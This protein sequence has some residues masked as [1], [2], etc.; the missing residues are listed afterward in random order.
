MYPTTPDKQGDCNLLITDN[1]DKLH[2]PEE[3]LR[4][5]RELSR[6]VKVQASQIVYL[7]E[8]AEGLERKKTEQ[9]CRAVETTDEL[10][11][12]KTQIEQQRLRTAR[13][14]AKSRK[15][16][17]TPPTPEVSQVLADLRVDL[18][19]G[20]DQ[21]HRSK[22]TLGEVT[23]KLLRVAQKQPATS[24]YSETKLKK[25][26][27]RIRSAEQRILKHERVTSSLKAQDV[28]GLKEL[29]KEELSLGEVVVLRPSTASTKDAWQHAPSGIRKELTSM[30]R[31]QR[32]IEEQIKEIERLLALEN[33]PVV[34]A[35]ASQQLKA[36]KT[37]VWESYEHE[38]FSSQRHINE[39]H[40][41]EADR[42][43]KEITELSSEVSMYRLKVR[44]GF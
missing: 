1:R 25:L 14:T 18:K 37:K 34:A 35:E 2:E 31:E 38:L 40:D 20:T 28:E 26:Q 5:Y 12:L 17:C 19:N 32:D 44:A 16:K 21:L 30:A 13:T 39:R 6:L 9:A 27:R 3:L 36:A 7:R 11:S 8:H 23:A 10:I 41:R 42:I 29:L 33:D 43:K 24:S 4:E 22:T 15:H